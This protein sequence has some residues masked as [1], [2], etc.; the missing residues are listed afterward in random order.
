MH[1]G[2]PVIGYN[3]GALP[4]TIGTG[5]IV[6]TEKKHAHLAHLVAE[7]A[8]DTPL[9]REMVARGRERVKQFHFD[10]F[11]ERVNVLLSR[12]DTTAHKRHAV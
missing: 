8:T 3:A 5:G 12:L 2:L 6:V 1:F 7:L 10:T 11:S 4:Q 9:R